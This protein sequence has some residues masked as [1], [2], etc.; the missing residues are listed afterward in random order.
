MQQGA[1]KEDKPIL[2]QNPFCSE[3]L[4]GKDPALPNENFTK[5]QIKSGPP[6][7]LKGQMILDLSDVND[8]V[9]VNVDSK[10]FFLDF[11]LW[12][13]VLMLIC[14][15]MD[16]SRKKKRFVAKDKRRKSP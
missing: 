14:L 11:K 9:D 2:A 4:T 6:T 13:S 7:A 1:E 5:V 10:P 8:D 15:K 3:L 12:A 16:G